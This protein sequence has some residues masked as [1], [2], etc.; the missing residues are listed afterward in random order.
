MTED[1]LVQLYWAI[2]ERWGAQVDSYWTRT[3]YFA[4]F[5]VAAI[6]GMWVVLDDKDIT[7][8][9]WYVVAI[10]LLIVIVLTAGW[11][12]SNLKSYDYHMY[13]WSV[14]REIER[15][16]G[17]SVSPDYVS[18]YETRRSR[19]PILRRLQYHTFTN[20]VVPIAFFIF[21]VSLVIG[22]VVH[23]WN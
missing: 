14:L 7:I 15:D 23:R 21:W 5:E 19:H 12:F 8:R 10:S 11:I 20:W 17:W 3:N 16:N 4:V 9:H 22:L 13:W 6:A 18:A 1:N 2:L